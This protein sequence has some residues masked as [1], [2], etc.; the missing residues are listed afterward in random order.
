MDPQD[1]LH[2]GL[3]SGRQFPPSVSPT[4][5]VLRPN[6]PGDF[7]QVHF[8]ET[9]QPPLVPWKFNARSYRPGFD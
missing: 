5:E 4:E 8:N 6:G 1:E 9:E 2:Q 3:P 7:G